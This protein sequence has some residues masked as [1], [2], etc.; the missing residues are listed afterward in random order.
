M[1][2]AASSIS[3]G[4]MGEATELLSTTMGEW[5]S[6]S[7]LALVQIILHWIPGV[8]GITVGVQWVLALVQ[9]VSIGAVSE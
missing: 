8:N 4:S 9:V 7:T 6:L 2:D 1:S 5:E 3:I